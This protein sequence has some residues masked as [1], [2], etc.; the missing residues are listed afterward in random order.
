MND[1]SKIA[2]KMHRKWKN[3]NKKKTELQNNYDHQ[4]LI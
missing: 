3:Q 2:V 4:E 1:F